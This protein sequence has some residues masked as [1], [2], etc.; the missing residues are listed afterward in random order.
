MLRR[1]YITCANACVCL[2]SLITLLHLSTCVYI[3][4]HQQGHFPPN[5]INCIMVPRRCR[6]ACVPVLV[7][8]AACVH[9]AIATCVMTQNASMQRPYALV[10]EPFPL[11]ALPGQK[12]ACPEYANLGCCTPD[13]NHLLVTKMWLLNA[14]MGIPPSGC[15]ACVETLRRLFCTYT[16][17]PRQGAYIVE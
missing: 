6:L 7:A 12:I 13:Q 3:A 15:P 4:A 8:V 1:H 10:H 16:C 11:D 14:T 2:V 5:L 9:E 17:S